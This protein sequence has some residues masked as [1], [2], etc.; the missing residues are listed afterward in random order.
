MF[1]CPACK[2]RTD[3]VCTDTSCSIPGPGKPFDNS[4]CRLCW[5]RLGLHKPP[6]N[7]VIQTSK[8]ESLSSK[9][10]SGKACIHLGGQT[11]ERVECKT[12]TGRV[13]LK[14][15]ECEIYG[16][17]TLEKSVD[18]IASCAGTI[19]NKLHT[20][21][22]N[23]KLTMR[24]NNK[25]WAYAIT[26]VPKRRS[27]LFPKTLASLNRAG[28]DKPRIFVDGDNDPI[29]W[30]REFGLITVCRGK[31]NI[32]THGN[33]ILA[34]H[35]L[36]IRNPTVDLYAMF[37]DDFITYPN[38]R[39]YLESCTY[40]DHG[41][42]NLYTFPSNQSVCKSGYEGWYL[43]NQNG[44][45]AVALVFNRETVLNLLGSQ[46]MIERPLDPDRGHR[47]IDGG[48]VTALNKLDWK[49]YVHNPSLVQHMGDFSTMGNKPH[50]KA[51]SFRG[52]EFDALSLIV[53]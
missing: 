45:G 41:Y 12:C 43:S 15:F 40:P 7:R 10:L 42:W 44:R 33:W 32:R 38:L 19:K 1:P 5:I 18:G 36:F 20:P 24:P 27:D 39:S 35:E 23:F 16:K 2:G 30:E 26:T 49:E 21:C 34:L 31:D 22:P 14:L 47:A 17:C 46:H 11:G 25:K 4:Q 50:K 8:K 52:E 48:I 13:E 37:Q 53:K 29:S 3:V 28:F 9:Y 6:T 51:E